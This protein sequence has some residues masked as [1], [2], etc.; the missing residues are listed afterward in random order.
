MPILQLDTPAAVA[1]ALA[2]DRLVLLKHSTRCPV[3]SWAWEH[4][5]QLADAHPEVDVAWVDVVQHR[6]LARALADHTGIPHES[7]Q[8]FVILDG[9]VHHHAS[10]MQ[11][12][13]D[14]LE[15]ALGLS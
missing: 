4:V 13:K 15:R 1:S 10:H 7:P 6:D 9:R 12:T 5:E 14:T 3:S 8:V 11:I 2:S